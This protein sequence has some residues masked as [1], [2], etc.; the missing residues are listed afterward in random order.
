MY[1]AFRLLFGKYASTFMDFKDMSLEMGEEEIRRVYLET[2]AYHIKRDTDINRECLD[3]IMSHVA[4]KTVLDIACGRGYLSAL[5]ADGHEVTGA[6]FFI[7]SGLK[8]K[9]PC[10]VF[11]EADICSLP[12]ADNEFDTVVCA[13][14]LEHVHDIRKAVSEIRRVAAKRLIVVVPKQRP[15]RHTFDL[16]LHFFPYRWSL[17]SLMGGGNAGTCELVGGDWYYAEDCVTDTAGLMPS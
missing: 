17:L 10:V 14:T 6:D 7:D 2:A 4:G 1:P 15:Y 8:K 13:H 11:R 5:L 3:R 12:F 9:M 16:H